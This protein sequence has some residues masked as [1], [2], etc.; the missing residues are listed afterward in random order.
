V[1]E[2]AQIGVGQITTLELAVVTPPGFTLESYAPPPP[3]P[4]LWLLDAES[5]PVE[6][7]DTRWIHRTRLRLR[8]RETGKHAWPGGRIA[9]E[10]PDGKRLELPLPEHPIEVVSILPEYPDRMTPFDARAPPAAR[11]E[12]GPVWGPAVMGALAAFAL[13]GLVALAKR[14]REAAVQEANAP[15]PPAGPPCWEQAR[16]ELA[17]ARGRVEVEPFEAAH[18]LSLGLRRFVERRFGADATGRTGE[19]LRAAEPP[20]AAR[21]RWP[22]LLALLGE[23]DELRFRP[24]SDGATRAALA[25]RLDALLDAGETFVE[26]AVPPEAYR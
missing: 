1:L 11:V 17:A 26:D 25:A 12:S 5:P 21:S 20:F 7:T 18:G 2:P 15:A 19:E 23:L 10:A 3:P 14:R 8:A 6:K 22:A 16:E 24:A 4:G 13:V 9:V